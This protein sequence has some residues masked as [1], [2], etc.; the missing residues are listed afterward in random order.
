MDELESHAPPPVV[1]LF[2]GAGGLSLGAAR[3]GFRVCAA[4]EL[5]EHA[6]AAH[7]RNFPVTRHLVADVAK[8]DG[9]SLMRE[10]GLKE[11]QLVGLI[12]GPPCQGF[13]CIGKNQRADTRNELFVHF[14]RLVKEVSPVFFVAENVPGLLC[15]RNGEL[16]HRALKQVSDRYA[17]LP[18][19][20]L[21]AQRY[22]APT[23]R[24][25]VFYIGCRADLAVDLR[26]SDF[27]PPAEVEMVTVRDALRGLPTRI[28][29]DWQ[30]EEQGWRKVSLAGDGYY[31]ER[32]H[33]NVPTGVGD[34]VALLRLGRES[35]AS[36]CWGTRHSPKV[37]DRYGALQPGQRDPVSKSHRLDLDG[38][39]PTIRA[40]TG[41]GR[42]RFQAVR[43]IH[44]TQ[45]R[46]IT[47]REA[48]RLQGFPDWFQFSATKWHSFRQIGNSVSP[49]LAERILVVIAKALGNGK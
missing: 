32:L 13:S 23:T 42:G 15:E 36:G 6:M 40:G 31:Q 35:R 12:G 3:A 1:D 22:G 9:R 49:I 8:F 18:P 7:K 26:E 34:P 47:P 30:S 41:P 5:D 16:R 14:F 17:L 27:T 10:V 39:C 2:S 20:K 28:S 25:R 24:T 45:S 43:P 37:A 33:G 21:A 4:V 44:P 19:M 11:R 38:F 46:V 48:A 29:P